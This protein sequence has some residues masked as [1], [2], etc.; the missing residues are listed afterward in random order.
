MNI[1]DDTGN[2]NEP[3]YSDNLAFDPDACTDKYKIAIDC[4]YWILQHYNKSTPVYSK[5][6][7]TMKKLGLEVTHDSH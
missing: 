7:E 2:N 6:T 5:V 4:F 1:Y 3:D